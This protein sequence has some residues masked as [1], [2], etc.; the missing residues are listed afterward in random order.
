MSFHVQESQSSWAAQELKFIS[1]FNFNEI[2]TSE[3]C[4][5]KNTSHDFFS[6]FFSSFVCVCVKR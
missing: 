5:F 6:L 4:A 3:F 2:L 1:A